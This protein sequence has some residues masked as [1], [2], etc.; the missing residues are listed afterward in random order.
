[1][2]YISRED[3]KIGYYCTEKNK[4]SERSKIRNEE[5]KI[6]TYMHMYN[7]ETVQNN[8]NNNKKEIEKET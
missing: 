4:E 2:M 6:H 7:L 3:E 1:M 8:N 5:S